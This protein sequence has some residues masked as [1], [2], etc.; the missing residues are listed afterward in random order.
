[1]TVPWST[2]YNEIESQK[3]VGGNFSLKTKENLEFYTD[4]VIPPFTKR[5]V[6]TCYQHI[7]LSLSDQTGI[8]I[9]AVVEAFCATDR[10]SVEFKAVSSRGN[11]G[12]VDKELQDKKEFTGV[13]LGRR[14]TSVV[15]SLFGTITSGQ[16]G[17]Q[18]IFVPMLRSNRQVAPGN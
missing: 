14:S 16:F 5:V 6:Q 9:Q 8:P 1:M 2:D 15:F 12:C 13:E 18:G 4:V 10:P 17:Y 7:E 3:Q 11:T